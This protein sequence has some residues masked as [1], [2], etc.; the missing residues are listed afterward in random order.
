MTV[1]SLHPAKILT[2]GEGGAV[3]TDDDELAGRLRRF[4]NHGIAT[5]LAARTDWTYAMVE[6]GYNYRLTDI[7]AALGSSQ[8]D[9]A[10]RVPG[11]AGAS[12]RR[13][14]SSG[15]PATRTSTSRSSSRAPTRPG[16][17][18]S[19]SSGSIGCGSIAAASTRRSGPRGSGS[20]ST[21]SRSTS[22]RTT[23]GGIPGLAFPVADAAYERLLTL[24]L[25]AGMTTADVD[26]VVAAL[27]KVTG[28]YRAV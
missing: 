17:S 27:D 19:P 6:L 2:T 5:E 1:L 28:A 20:T 26:D 24:P 10:R 11:D 7:G 4:R 23:A 25:Y 14:T 21:T 12:S 18:A 9:P 3:L 13:A 8:L 22:I 16:T 15:W